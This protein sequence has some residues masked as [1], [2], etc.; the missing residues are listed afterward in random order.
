MPANNLEF[1]CY[2]FCNFFTKPLHPARCWLEIVIN[3]LL[4][5][6]ALF[7]NMNQQI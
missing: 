4:I 3:P 2:F 1:F 6:S 7:L 5:I